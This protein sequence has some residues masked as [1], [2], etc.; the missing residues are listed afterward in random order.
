MQPEQ[1]IEQ[2]IIAPEAPP[3]DSTP[4]KK[5]HGKRPGAGRKPNPTNLLRGVSKESHT[6][7]VAN[8]RHCRG[9][10]WPAAQQT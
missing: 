1:Q 2:T 5:Q 10:L 7:A 6:D 3:A 9:C 8:I 4:I